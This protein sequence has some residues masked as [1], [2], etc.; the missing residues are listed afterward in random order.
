M[1]YTKDVPVGNKNE[2]S[3]SLIDGKNISYGS[4]TPDGVYIIKPATREAVN[5]DRKISIFIESSEDGVPKPTITTIS[6]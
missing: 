1:Y 2:V 3:C 4:G 6:L 5:K